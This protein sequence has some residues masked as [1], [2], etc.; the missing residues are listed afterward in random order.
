MSNT[1]IQQSLIDIEQNLRKLESARNQVGGV[2]EKT[3][4]L[5]ESIS[6]VISNVESIREAFE[7]EESYLKKGVQNSLDA[8]KKDLEKSSEVALRKASDLSE[9]QDKIISETILKLEEFQSKLR[10]VQKSLLDFDLE[11]SLDGI[12]GEISK[13]TEE[14][15]SNQKKNSDILDEI[16]SEIRANQEIVAK[17]AK[18]NL[19]LLAVGFVLVIVVIFITK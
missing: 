6:S 15:N 2:A 4:R 16:K 8:F 18:Q 7:G 17:N 10:D 1:L 14:V 19:L 5:I 12:R 11:K 13:L 9:K 3:E